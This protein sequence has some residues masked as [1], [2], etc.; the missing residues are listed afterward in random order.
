MKDILEFEA[1]NFFDAKV[2]LK[3]RRVEFWLKNPK[4]LVGIIPYKDEEDYKSVLENVSS[5]KTMK[6]MF[7]KNKKYF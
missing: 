3:E 7:E 4:F 1:Y 6:E 5:L 2:F